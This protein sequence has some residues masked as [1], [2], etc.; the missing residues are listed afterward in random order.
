M[1]EHGAPPSRRTERIARSIVQ[2]QLLTGLA[3]LLV[4]WIVAIVRPATLAEPLMFGGV[5]AMFVISGVTLA[6]PWTEKT[7]RWSLLLPFLDI[8]AIAAVRAGEP[9][10][11]AGLLLVLPILWIARSYRAVASVGA[12][13]LATAL[14][15]ASRLTTGA[16]FSMGDLA[17][18]ALLPLTL[19]FIA[20]TARLGGARTTSQR[21]LLREQARLIE[22]ALDRARAQERLLDEV[23][24]AVSFG[25]VAYDRDGRVILM[26]EA[27]RRSLTR[28]GEPRSAVVHPVIYQADRATAYPAESRPFGR[29]VRGESFSGITYWVGEP[30][31]RQAAYSATARA[32]R[33]PAGE[34]DGGVLVLRDVTAEL[35]AIRAR[36]SLIGSVSHEL[37]TPITSILG[38]L[39]L[40]V[41]APGLAD[42]TRRMIGIAQRNAER[43]LALVTDLLLAASDADQTLTV[44]VEPTDLAELVEQAVEGQRFAADERRIT[45]ETDLVPHA[46]AMVDALRIRQVV[47]NLLSNAV[48]Y[49]RQ[50]GQIDVRL[51]DDGDA[52]IRLAVADTG[53]GIAEADLAQLFDRFFRTETARRSGAVGSG[54]GLAIAR[55]IVRQHGGDLTVASALGMGTVFTLVLPRSAALADP[56]VVGDQ[57]I[58]EP[59]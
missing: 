10:I 3:V 44:D 17:S 9:L 22:E 13:T 6:V 56:H 26:N 7:R 1:S 33:T 12:V 28:F 52:G 21:T 34:P 4:V 37:R 47:D 39:E 25:V 43:L 38:Y 36:D 59:S 8:V 42:E 29:A 45:I 15:W 41:D 51:I 14:L 57:P 35:D 2:S 58:R 11:G 20:A 18:L 48:K 30:G 55:D 32:L 5:I 40:A 31:A 54:L 27:Y 24:N 16:P 19:A 46:L 49:N 50:G 53:D 23:L